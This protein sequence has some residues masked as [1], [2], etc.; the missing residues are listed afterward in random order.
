MRIAQELLPDGWDVK[1]MR[2]EFR[3]P[4]KM[5]DTLAIFTAEEGA[6][7]YVD[8]QVDGKSSTLVEFE[9]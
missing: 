5:G 8:I 2:V 9:K 4:A 7:F 3:V 1:S 6:K